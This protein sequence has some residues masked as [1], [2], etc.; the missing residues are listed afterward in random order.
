M[1]IRDSTYVRGKGVA[2]VSGK[3]G[4]PWDFRTALKAVG[5]KNSKNLSSKIYHFS[6]IPKIVMQY[7]LY[8]GLC[9]SKGIEAA[10]LIRQLVRKI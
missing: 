8:E 6:T 7:Q 1:V 5:K 2:N 10:A 4:K 3:N 9:G